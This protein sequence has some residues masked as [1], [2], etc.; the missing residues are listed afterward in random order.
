MAPVVVTNAAALA[1]RP[2]E[3]AWCI[4]SYHFLSAFI[5]GEKPA[6]FLPET[7]TRGHNAEASQVNNFDRR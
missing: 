4:R 2:P 1:E 6:L 7:G 3:P 5:S